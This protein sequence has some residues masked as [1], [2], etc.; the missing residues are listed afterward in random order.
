M[1]TDPLIIR[2][3]GR[4]ISPGSGFFSCCSVRLYHIV[5]YFNKNEYLPPIVDSSE[6]FL[7]YKN[8]ELDD[9][10]FCYFKH[11]D[12]VEDFAYENSVDFHFGYQFKP[13]MKLDYINLKLFMKKYFSP[14]KE[15]EEKIEE[16]KSKYEIDYNNTCVLFYRGNDKKTETSLKSYDEI[17]AHGNKILENDPNI[18]ILIQ[19]DETEFIE[20]CIEKFKNNI[21]FKDEIRTMTKRNSSVDKCDQ[22]NNF[23]YSK[24]FLAIVIIMSKCKYFVTGSM[25]NI[26][27][28][29]C[30]YRGNNDNFY[31]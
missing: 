17:I 14:S 31:F 26:P 23:H 3:G 21:V 27:M 4:E 13:N 9:I 29:V 12:E 6:Q 2:H 20:T 7:L 16:L 8:N 10:T 28:F 19:S 30:L 25:G 24:Y 5:N 18:K 11:Y 15:I 22:K 1:H